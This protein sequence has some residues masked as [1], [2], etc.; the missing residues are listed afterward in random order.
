VFRYPLLPFTV[1]LRD[2]GVGNVDGGFGPLFWGSIVPLGIATGTHGVW[3]AARRDVTLRALVAWL[4]L[5]AALPYLLAPAIMFEV[6]ARYLLAPAIFGFAIA[7]AALERVRP[8]WPRAAAVATVAAVGVA[9]IGIAP[10]A[11]GDDLHARK[12]LLRFGPAV[13]A[14]RRGDDASPWRFV[15]DASYGVGQVAVAWDLLDALGTPERPLWI[16]ATG[17]YPAGFYGTRLQHRIW[18]IPAATR[19]AEPDVLVYHFERRGPGA[20]AYY[21]EPVIR[22]ETIASRPDRYDVVLATPN[23]VV[24]FPR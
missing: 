5:A 20:V 19:P 24:A 10:I 12:Q 11:D 13:E 6:Q 16:Y 8:R 21:G 1:S 3:R 7:A 17:S 15:G 4:M 14:A 18:N 23:L 9:L 22:W 2:L